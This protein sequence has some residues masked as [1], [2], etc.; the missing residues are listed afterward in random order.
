MRYKVSQCLTRRESGSSSSNERQTFHSSSS[1]SS[2]LPARPA[3]FAQ[4][5]YASGFGQGSGDREPNIHKVHPGLPRHAASLPPPLPVRMVAPVV[6]PSAAYVTR[7]PVRPNLDNTVQRPH[8]DF[9]VS[10]LPSPPQINIPANSRQAPNLPPRRVQPSPASRHPPSHSHSYSMPPSVSG[11]RQEAGPVP[12]EQWR[13]THD[14]SPHPSAS[15]RSPPSVAPTTLHFF[16]TPAVAAA[17]LPPEIIDGLAAVFSRG[18]SGIPLSTLQAV[19]QGSSSADYQSVIKVLEIQTHHPSF[20]SNLR[21]QEM[22]AALRKLQRPASLARPQ[23]SSRANTIGGLSPRTSPST[24]APAQAQAA[25][26]APSY[27][28][29]LAN[30]RTSVQAQIEQNVQQTLAGYSTHS[31]QPASNN[32]PPTLSYE[33]SMAE[34]RAAFQSKIAEAVRLNTMQFQPTSQGAPPNPAPAQ[35]PQYPMQAPPPP[36][37]YYSAPAPA[38]PQ[39]YGLSVAEQ[40][41]EFMNAYNNAAG[42]NSGGMDQTNTILSAYGG[43]GGSSIDQLAA[44]MSSFGG[45]GGGGMDQLTALM[46]GLGGS[47]G[48][49]MDQL[50]ASM[51]GLGGGGSGTD[52]LTTLM[53]GLGAGGF[54]PSSLLTGLMGM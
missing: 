52:Q 9:G 41:T 53:S 38:P 45:G 22:I 12:A 6:A 40:Y 43:G 27:E 1:S 30:L 48:G 29:A 46:S 39:N 4:Q 26:A 44:L 37:P 7:S 33:E 31:S 15:Q 21:Y 23:S 50:T 11:Q 10:R 28:D 32:A 17:V 8:S 3:S 18:G 51:S 5:L 13:F 16:G 42:A 47:G 19:I 54:D 25:P 24:R 49:S 14:H 20:Q 35:Y 2:S 36:M 34:F